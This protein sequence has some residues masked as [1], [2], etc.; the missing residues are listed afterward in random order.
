MDI[1]RTDE[2]E[3]DEEGNVWCKCTFTVEI[4]SFSRRT[5]SEELPAGL[6]GARV[7]L[8]RWCCFD[9]HYK[10]GVKITLTPEETERVLKGELDLTSGTRR[11]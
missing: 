4:V 7:K 2:S 3:A 5:P 1:A 11:S 8:A 10:T 6:R 9:W